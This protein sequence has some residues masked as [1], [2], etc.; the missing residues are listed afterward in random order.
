MPVSVSVHQLDFIKTYLYTFSAIITTPCLQLG[1]LLI[2]RLRERRLVAAH[3]V[4]Q[5]I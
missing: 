2:M 1:E 5:V 4:S 3:G